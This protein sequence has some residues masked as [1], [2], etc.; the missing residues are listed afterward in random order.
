MLKPNGSLI[1]N[2]R[3]AQRNHPASN[4]QRQRIPPRFDTNHHD[5]RLELT[6]A[7]V[8]LVHHQLIQSNRHISIFRPVP[9]AALDGLRGAASLLA[10]N[11][12]K[13]FGLDRTTIPAS[14]LL[15]AHFFLSSATTPH[16]HI[17]HCS[18]QHCSRPQC[19]RHGAARP[20]RANASRGT[21]TIVHSRAA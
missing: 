8:V 9:T 15:P 16:H 12:L 4:T 18:T 13:H 7:C 11:V 6:A 14:H 21:F 2:Y 10:R 1:Q 17:R 19:S 3:Q 20:N 5:G